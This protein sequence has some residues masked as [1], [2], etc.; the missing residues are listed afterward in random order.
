[1][2]TDPAGKPSKTKFEV[3]DAQLTAVVEPDDGTTGPVILI[4]RSCGIYTCTTY[5]NRQETNDFANAG[6]LAAACGLLVAVPPLAAVC[7]AYYSVIVF[8]AMRARDRGMCLKIKQPI[9]PPAL[10]PDI[11]SGGYCT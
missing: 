7:A 8:Q 6:S 9:Y 3:T 4:D 11:Y 2:A 10:I 5:F 1:L